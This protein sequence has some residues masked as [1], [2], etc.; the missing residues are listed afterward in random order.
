MDCVSACVHACIQIF[1]FQF[2]D[3][4][5]LSSSHLAPCLRVMRMTVSALCGQRGYSW[6]G[7]FFYGL[8]SLSSAS[9]HV[10]LG[11]QVQAGVACR[12]SPCGH[13]R[14]NWTMLVSGLPHAWLLSHTCRGVLCTSS[15]LTE[16]PLLLSTSS[17]GPRGQGC[18]FST[19]PA[20]GRTL[21]TQFSCL[22]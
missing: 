10:F 14:G 13:R 6:A 2:G 12:P 9:A 18:F 16:A 8:C 1:S 21:Q 7:F 22:F 15:V 3:R 11:T 19:S 5:V 4:P 20:N 17:R